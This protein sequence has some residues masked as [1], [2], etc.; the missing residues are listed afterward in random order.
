M[1]VRD[2]LE[3]VNKSVSERKGLC[4]ICGDRVHGT[5]NYIESTEGYCH[6]KCLTMDKR[7]AKQPVQA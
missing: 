3:K 5:E 1:S 6:K 4:V 7:T 2:K